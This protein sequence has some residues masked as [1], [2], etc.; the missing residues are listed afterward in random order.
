MDQ[1]AK[2]DRLNISLIIILAIVFVWSVT[3]PNDMFTWFLEMMPIPLGLIVLAAT[4]RKFRLTPLA[5]VLIWIHAV[6]LLVGAH[7]T[8]AQV[9]LF[10]WIRDAFDLSRNHYDRLGHFAQGFIPA[11][12]A[13]EVL[14]R[15]S[16]LRKGKWLFFIVVCVC[17]S[18]SACY[19]LIE[20]LVAVFTGTA[21][22]AFLGTQGDQW[23]TQIDMA[24][25]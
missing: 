1:N 13:R 4:Y 23:D 17:L 11:V 20:W 15:T 3:R 10:D 8:Y 16:P 18:I 12:L 25:A 21:A 6:I 5:Y 14:L 7:Y 2:I 19:E 22:E 24:L 9:P